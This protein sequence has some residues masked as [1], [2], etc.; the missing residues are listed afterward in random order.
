[1]GK[2]GDSRKGYKLEKIEYSANGYEVLK[3]GDRWK[4]YKVR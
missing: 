4:G 1:M 2:F 3:I